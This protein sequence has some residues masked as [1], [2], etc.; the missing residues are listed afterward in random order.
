MSSKCRYFIGYNFE[1]KFFYCL[2]KVW[3]M[4][5][6]WLDMWLGISI[7][8]TNRNLTLCSV[9]KARFNVKSIYR[10]N[11]QKK[12]PALRHYFV[13]FQTLKLSTQKF[14]S[15]KKKVSTRRFAPFF[16]RYFTVL[17]VGICLFPKAEFH[18]THLVGPIVFKIQIFTCLILK[19]YTPMQ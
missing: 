14:S 13:E 6:S 4:Q 5:S 8:E 12:H 9:L 18:I 3:T 10:I 1:K 2:G 11:P 15:D 17:T 16:C 7:R 19:F